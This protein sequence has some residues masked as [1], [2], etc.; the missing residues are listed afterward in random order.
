[1]PTAALQP[2]GGPYVAVVQ[3]GVCTFLDK[4][5][6]AEGA[7]AKG[8]IIVS[9]N[10]SVPSMGADDGSSVGIFVLDVTESFG[11]RVRNLTQGEDGEKVAVTMSVEVYAPSLLNASEAVLVLMATCLVAAGAIVSTA[12]ISDRREGSFASAVAAPE[13]EVLEV[14]SLLAGGFCVI[15]SCFLLFLFF[16]MQYMIYFIIFAFCLGGASCI[17]QFGSICLIHQYPGLKNKAVSVPVCGPVLHAEIIAGIPALILVTTW[18]CL[19]NTPYA[20]PFQD[21]IGA[22]FLCWLQRTLRLP[23]IRVASIL[24]SAMFCFDIFW[25]FISPLIFQQSV[26]VTV[27]TGANTGEHVPMLLRIPAWG[28]PFGKE[29]MLGFGDIALPGLLV[30]FL[31]RHDLMS[32]RT[33]FA[34]YFGPALVGYFV[35]LCVTI[36]AL[37]IMQMGQPAL[38]YLVPGTLGTTLVLGATRCELQ[39]LWDGTPCS[40]DGWVEQD[41]GDDSP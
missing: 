6:K 39:S 2:T 31:R 26:M 13:D 36:A 38:L 29:R 21:A 41:S 40:D 11:G 18:V 22:G 27:A 33:P 16:F 20:W 30:S 14:D 32:K 7:G 15:G 4:A 23:N 34:G 37:T 10:E 24:L 35:G 8:I 12:D 3:R 1:V 5:K 19:R 25:V 17:A 9:N 28:D